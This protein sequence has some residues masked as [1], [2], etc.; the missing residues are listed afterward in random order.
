MAG[1]CNGVY[2]VGTNDIKGGTL[3]CKIY[4]IWKNMIQRC[5][6][7]RTRS[8]YPTYLDCTVCDDWLTFS[9][10][11]EWVE[12]QEWR[13]M[14]LDKDILSC[15]KKIYSP[16]TC[17]FIDGEL[18]KVLTHRKISKNNLP[19]GVNFRRSTGRYLSQATSHGK[20]IHLGSFGTP[21]EASDAYNS[22]KASAILEWV[23]IE[24]DER[25]RS[26]L[27]RIIKDVMNGQ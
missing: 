23:V 9:N 21:D 6:S 20:H 2:G 16:E 22:H 15:N 26:G 25:V 14:H 27:L 5:Y 10:F 3:G 24:K 18:N 17:V 12:L 7:K 13:G 4:V 19:T 11:K 1:K 8:K